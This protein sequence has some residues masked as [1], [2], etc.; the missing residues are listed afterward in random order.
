MSQHWVQGREKG[1]RR[2]KI[3]WLV[4]GIATFVMAV[5]AGRSR[6]ALYVGRVA[7]GVLYVGAGA[8]VN[9]VYL[10]TGTD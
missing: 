4:L 10:A 1:P 9:A 6:P 2:G 8:L 7:L 3:A 5:R